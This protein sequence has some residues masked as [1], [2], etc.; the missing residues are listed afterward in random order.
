M[1]S[2]SLTWQFI[3]R[4]HFLLN[5]FLVCSLI[6]AFVPFNPDIYAF[7]IDASWQFSLNQA[8]AQGLRFGT[9]IIFTFGPYAVLHTQT[10]HPATDMMMLWGTFYLAISYWLILFFLQKEIT[11][12]WWFIFAIVLSSFI[13][14][15]DA[16]F[17]TL[18]LAFAL[19]VFKQITEP[20]PLK[21]WQF[22]LFCLPLGLLPLTK[23]SLLILCIAI[24]ML[25]TFALFEHRQRALAITS[26]FTPIGALIFFWLLSGQ[27]LIDLPFYLINIIPLITGYSEA[28]AEG[29]DF[30][31]IA[32]YLLTS[33]VFLGTIASQRQYSS[34]QRLFLGSAFAVFFFVAFKA[35]FVRH[36]HDHELAAIVALILAA[37]L[38]P[39]ILRGRAL[40]LPLLC[41]WVTWGYVD[42]HNDTVAT[43]EVFNR[44]TK[45][46][47]TALDAIKNRL[48]HP[49]WKQEALAEN[50]AVLKKEA[51]FPKIES[52]ADIYSFRQLGFFA[53]GIQWSPRPI[54][55]SY[56][57]YTPA[58]AQANRDFLLSKRA[59]DNII[60]WIEPIDNRFPS[61][62]DGLSWAVFLSHYHPTVFSPRYLLLR[63]RAQ[64][65]NPADVLTMAT[66]ST[67]HRIGDTLTLPNSEYPLYAKIELRP[68]ML[69]RL[70]KSLFK[71]NPLQISI[72]LE[73]GQT[74]Q[75]RI[76]SGMAEAGFMVSPLIESPRDFMLLYGR[77][78]R[79]Q[80]KQVKTFKIELPEEMSDYLWQKEFLL[81]LG[82][83]YIP[84]PITV[85]VPAD[86]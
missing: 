74:R 80:E 16:L 53:S 29:G 57:A 66:R 27:A 31:E 30:Y 8:V 23:G 83:V 55:Q 60:F 4:N 12:Y 38:L 76:I 56:S 65:S 40:L 61:L 17:F 50:Q 84:D 49:T 32:A 42:S 39:L 26:F 54:F 1:L 2:Q 48:L 58:L 77:Q 52:N 59:P 33:L 14:S 62:E 70:V 19:L 43:L 20:M 79:L 73:N 22:A 6:I 24:Q 75:Y 13:Y 47:T 37:C 3:K 69:G 85:N 63:K 82:Q 21:I 9:D 36:S 67:L 28:M 44:F 68:S 45:N 86:F 46:Y 72:T 11:W 18:P 25:S 35:G 51:D 64:H 78:Q 10:Y 34:S 71:L 81:T 15:R 5:L 41:A 7:G